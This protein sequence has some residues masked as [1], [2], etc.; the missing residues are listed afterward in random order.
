ME[1]NMNVETMAPIPG[2]ALRAPDYERGRASIWSCL[3]SLRKVAPGLLAMLFIAIFSNNLAGSPNPFTLENLFAYLDNVI[4]PVNHQPF[5]QIMNA[6]FV[7]NALLL[8][9]VV[10][11]AFG[12]P[13]SWKPG[14]SYIHKLMPL[15]IILLG[16]HFVFSHA[17]KAGLG[18]ILFAAAMLLA[19][20][21]LTLAAG[22]WLKVDDRHASVVAGGLATG[23]PHV[24]A[25]LMPM[26]KAKGGQ[27]ANAA[28]SV[29]VFG[30]LAALAFPW[31]ARALDLPAQ[32][33]GLGAALAIG[34]GAQ[35]ASAGLGVS[36]EA[37][38]Y[39]RYYDVVRHALMPAG[40]LYV[41]GLM[42]WRRIRRPGDA[43]V[44]ATR[45]LDSVPPY[46]FVF[47]L[48]WG[49]ANVHLFREPTHLAVFNLVKWDFSLAAAALGL[50]LPLR[51]I[52][53]WGLRGLVLAS[54]VGAFR[55]L[56]MLAALWACAKFGWLGL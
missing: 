55:L 51:E 5:F 35:A 23:D 36:Y 13:D 54:S 18:P 24:C 34:N 45:G 38:R 3:Y 56:V 12:V 44:R 42:F 37:G 31:L 10:G 30:A 46:L 9:L 41:F 15:G 20:A 53:E 52:R 27:V 1:P 28:A 2:G 50:S 43:S 29:I 22:R 21:P 39:A 14:L 19:T 11:N 33:A 8:G 17:A 4:G 47:A 49:L 48:V 25:I 6:N 32:A 26:I 7:W 40:F 16:P